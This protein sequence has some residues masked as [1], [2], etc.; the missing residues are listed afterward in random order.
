PR[1]RLLEAT[2]ASCH[3]RGSG[4]IHCPIGGNGGRRPGAVS[5][6]SAI[7][8][9]VRRMPR[10]GWRAPWLRT[11]LLLRSRRLRRS[12]LR[13][14]SHL[15]PWNLTRWLG[16]RS[17]R[18]AWKCA[19]RL[20]TRRY[21]GPGDLARLR[22]RNVPRLRALEPRL[23]ALR[24]LSLV[25]RQRFISRLIFIARRRDATRLAPP[26]GR[27]SGRLVAAR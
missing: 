16:T 14:G 1:R 19:L 15:R 6:S 27:R 13:S 10:R 21:L 8:R 23:V 5:Q 7:L 20:R 11:L 26:L 25:A 22:T 3:D 2:R 9:R 18:R 4:K 24:R 17:W 12:H